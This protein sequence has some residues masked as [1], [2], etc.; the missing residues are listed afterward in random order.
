MIVAPA[1]LKRVQLVLQESCPEIV[2]SGFRD[3]EAG[4]ACEE[5]MD[6][7]CQRTKRARLWNCVYH[8]IYRHRAGNLDSRKRMRVHFFS[9]MSQHETCISRGPAHTNTGAR[10]DVTPCFL[11]AVLSSAKRLYKRWL[12]SRKVW[13][14]FWCQKIST[15]WLS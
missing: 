2:R 5:S 14:P 3:C 6:K 15:C 12:R 10:K 9:G 4:Q 13:C 11:L 8:W 1:E 7:A